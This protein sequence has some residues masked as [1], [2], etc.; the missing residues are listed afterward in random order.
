MKCLEE[1]VKVS[2]SDLYKCKQFAERF[3]TWKE[4]EKKLPD[5]LATSWF[6]V[7][8]YLL[9]GTTTQEVEKDKLEKQKVC[10]HLNLKVV[11][12]DCS[13]VFTDKEIKI[14]FIK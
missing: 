1:D 13:K 6:K 9:P 12:K 10:Q 4:A 7:S 8:Q 14:D 11:C 2:Q 5:G 3:T